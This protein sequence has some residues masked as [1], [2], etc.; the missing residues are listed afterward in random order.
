MKKNILMF[1][2][3][4]LSISVYGQKVGL[5]LSGGGAKGLYHV[6]LIKALEENNVPID[7][8]SGTSMGSIV[9]VMYAAGYTPEEMIKFFISDSVQGWLD[10]KIPEQYTYFFKRFEPTPEMVSINI[11]VGVK[12]KS[13]VQLPVNIISPYKIDLAFMTM[14]Q[15]QSWAANQNFD[16]LFVP[17]RCVASDVY[18]KK[19]V[20]FKN[21][22]LPFAVRASMSIPFVFTPLV[23]DSVLLYDGGLYDNFPYKTM[24]ED[25]NPDI[26]IG[27]VCA[28]NDPNPKQDDLLGQIMVMI[29]NPTN[30][31]L[32]D[33]NDVEVKRIFEDVGMLEYSKAAFIMQKGYEDAMEKMPQI[34]KNIKRR[35]TPDEVNLKRAKFKEKVRPLY[36]E[37]ITIEGLTDKQKGFVLRQLG[38]DE[39]QLFT[40]DYFEEKYMRILATGLFKGEFPVVTF[41][42]ESGYFKLKLK[43]STKPSLKVSIGG[44]VSSTSLNQGYVALD[45]LH[46]TSKASNH[47][48]RGYFGTFYNAVVL[49][50]R[51]DIYTQFPFY[52]EYRMGYD[53][54][55]FE[56]TNMSNYYRNKDFRFSSSVNWFGSLTAATSVLD[57]WAARGYVMFNYNSSRYFAGLHTSQDKSDLSEFLSAEIGAALQSRQANFTLYSSQGFNRQIGVRYIAGIESF[58]PGSNSAMS[59]SKGKNRQ[60]FEVKLTNQHDFYVSKWFNFG[61][62]VEAVYSNHPS[63]RTDVYSALTMPAFTPTPHSETLFMPEYRSAAYVGLGIA[64]IFK[65]TKNEKFYLKTYAYAFLPHEMLQPHPQPASLMKGIFGGTFIYQTPIGPASFN[66]TKYTTGPRNWAYVLS[67]GYAIF[68]AR[69]SGR[70]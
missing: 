36:F 21:G 64:P 26:I 68:N 47:Y 10:G 56:T 17:F 2:T 31:S 52:L 53:D 41:N 50:G 59:A 32:P 16:S 11:N 29:T 65:F 37:Q 61:Y 69:T 33:S 51:Q 35:V 55:N 40:P 7:Y 46:V 54:S 12:E 28:Q 14:L 18:N 49:G 20:V 43:M 24:K 1:L 60:W 9:G 4:L 70:H 13:S 38:V 66:V 39:H 15:P 6:G 23:Y 45:Y 63:F 57:N 5:V 67:F 8:V 42:R 3:M 58:N 34:L 19:A 22:S 48:F 25:F 30:Y 44:N 62:L 27:G